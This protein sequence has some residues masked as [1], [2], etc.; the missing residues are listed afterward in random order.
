VEVRLLS[1]PS[2]A[3]TGRTASAARRA[4]GRLPAVRYLFSRGAMAWRCTP[5]M[6][7]LGGDRP[8]HICARLRLAAEH[9]TFAAWRLLRRDMPSC[10]A[11]SLDTPP[12]WCHSAVCAS[13]KLPARAAACSFLG[14]LAREPG[15]GASPARTWLLHAFPAAARRCR[16]F[17]AW[18]QRLPPFSRAR[19]TPLHAALL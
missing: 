8:L 3:V 14:W 12:A 18:R 6:P 15:D 1:R 4:I 10:A 11:A 16:A 7:G 19:S 9:A 13:W 2:S 17:A 5:G